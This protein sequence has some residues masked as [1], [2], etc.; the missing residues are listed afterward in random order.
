MSVINRTCEH[1]G[2]SLPETQGNRPRKLKPRRFYCEGSD[3]QEAA[4]LEVAAL[5][6][7]PS[8]AGKIRA[9][10]PAAPTDSPMAQL[11]AAG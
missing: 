3:C 9:L 10:I 4:E 6:V 5:M 11:Q 8:L 7:R 1:C 2:R